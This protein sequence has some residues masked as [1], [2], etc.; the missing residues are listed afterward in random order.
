[1]TTA[2]AIFALVLGTASFLLGANLDR[3]QRW[4]DKR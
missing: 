2:Y 4:L 1:M 3:F